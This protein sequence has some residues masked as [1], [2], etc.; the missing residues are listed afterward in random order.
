MTLFSVSSER[1]P[2]GP[3]PRAW[4][5]DGSV[6]ETWL[7]KRGGRLTLWSFTLS[8]SFLVFSTVLHTHPLWLFLASHV[9]GPL[10]SASAGSAA[11]M[12][13]RMRKGNGQSLEHGD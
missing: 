1:I 3:L 6:L 11:L 8:P 13:A 12:C 2:P 5:L 4:S 9:V 7:G 10:W